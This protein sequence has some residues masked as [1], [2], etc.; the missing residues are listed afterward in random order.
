MKRAQPYQPSEIEPKWQAKWEK[1]NLYRSLIDY[2]K[3]KHYALTMLPYPSGDLHIGHWY[4]MAPSDARARFM[5]MRGYNV[6]FPMGFDAFGLPAENAAV[7]HGIHPKQWT[8]SNI[9][10][11]RK[12]LRSMGAMF[13]WEREA[14]S[15]D[16]EY[17]RWTQWFFLKLFKHDLAYRKMAPVDWCPQCNTTLAREQVWGEDRHCERCGTPVIKKNLEQ[18][19]FRITKYAEELLDFSHLDW[20]ER[21]RVLQTNW[22]GR[23]EGAMVRFSTEQGDDL[24]VFTTR[25]DTL[26]GATFMVLAPEHPL[27][28]KITTPEHREEVAEYVLL[29]LRQSDIQREALGKEKT[30]VFTGGYAVNPVN[31]ERIPIWI[32]DYVLMTYGTG[33]IMAVP[34]HDERDFEFALKFGLPIIPVI[35]HP[36]A[37][38][39]SLIRR[40]FVTEEFVQYLQENHMAKGEDQGALEVSLEED[41]INDF[42]V[43]AQRGLTHGWIEIVGAEW[44]FIFPDQTLTLSSIQ[45]DREILARIQ[46][47]D[48]AT[49]SYRTTMEYLW[50][51]PYYRD[52]LYHAEYGDMIHSGE[53]SG[54]KGEEAIQKVIR[55]L[56][57]RGIGQA[58]VNYRLR[59][60]L[61]SRQRYWGAPIPIIYCSRCGIVPVPEDQ[62]PVLLPEDV[63]WLPTGESPLKLHPTWRFTSCP[64]CGG[65]AERETDTM[66]TFMCSSW[67]HLRYLSPK[68]DQGPFDPEEYDYWMPVDTYTG[69][70]EHATMH[71]IYTRFFHK[72]CRDMGITKGP[73]PMIQLRNQGIILGEDSEKMSKSRGNVVAPDELVEKYGA[74]TVRAYLM[75]FARWDQGAPWSSTGIEGTARWLRKVWATILEEPQTQNQ[76]S[77]ETLRTLRRKVH[78]TIRSVT[79]DYEQFEFNTVIS[80]LM[81]LLNVMVD[82][83]EAGAFGTPEWEEAIDIY[84]RLMA[85]ATP[86]IAEELWFLL[87]KPYSI[88]TQ[89]WPEVDEEAAKEEMFT[90]VIQINGRVRDRVELPVSASEEEAKRAALESPIVQKHLSGSAPKQVIYVRGRLVNI[91]VN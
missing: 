8:Y 81:E 63:E 31:N 72:A 14:I 86:H 47:I 79:R 2:S 90:L 6:L 74:D 77:P 28:E 25:P 21:V 33:A 78:Q 3:K 46:R 10:R 65:P 1:D 45:A 39:K 73:E 40:S 11:M 49:R 36:R 60:W 58:K 69:G 43:H 59:D 16:P 13:D 89:P 67:Y 12:Q 85:P 41:Q 20:P 54:T 7:K 80:S 50:N 17:Y 55:W 66:D 75:F 44:M 83:K 5:R 70:I 23:S 48:A 76:A 53:L 62:L 4:A 91:V 19:F 84:L 68:Y 42:V 88:H 82:A 56:E 51:Q 37:L 9:E 52:V 61:I 18:W 57:T 30:G 24:E 64:T 38:R 27:V 87:G 29:T 22:I 71:L 35:Q 34:A 26:W 32:A 15:S